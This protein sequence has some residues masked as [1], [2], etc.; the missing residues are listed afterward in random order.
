M[1]TLALL[2][3]QATM[4]HDLLTQVFAPV[5]PIQGA[6]R[7]EGSTANAIT[8]TVL[9]VYTSEDRLIS[10]VMGRPTLWE[11]GEWG[12]RLGVDPANP[13]AMAPL[14]DLAPCREYASAVRAATMALLPTLDA[15]ALDRAIPTPRGA[16]PL[17]EAL[18]FALVLN[19]VVHLGEIAALMGCQGERGFPF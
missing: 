6:W 1:D 15:A 8:P 11:S 4:A 12:A 14:D 16:R 3:F 10:G 9:H 7:L 18:S 2:N 19:K 17:G 13:W 5:T